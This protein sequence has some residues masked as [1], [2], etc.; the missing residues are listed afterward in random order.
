MLRIAG[1][2]RN[3]SINNKTYDVPADADFKILLSRYKSEVI[4]TTGDNMRKMT[5]QSEAIM[6]LPII[7]ATDEYLLL[8]DSAEGQLDVNLSITLADGT[9]ISSAGFFNFG[10]ISSSDYKA[11]LDLYPLTQWAIT[12]P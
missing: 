11:T 2:P 8:R 5:K 4:A 3:V 12:L 1:T 9:I 10:E 6:G 7:V